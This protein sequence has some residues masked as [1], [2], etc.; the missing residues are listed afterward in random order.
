MSKKLRCLLAFLLFF[1]GISLHAATDTE[2]NRYATAADAA[3]WPS[4]NEGDYIFFK[5]NNDGGDDIYAAAGGRH[6]EIELPVGKKILIYEGDYERILING[7]S[8]LGTPENPTIVTN[9]GGQVRWGYSEESNQYRSLELYNFKHLHLTGKYDAAN[10][11]GD[12]QFLGHDSGAALG[13][14]DYYERYGLWGNPRWSGPTYRGKYG[15][16]VRIFRFKTVKIDYVS[17]WGGYF[18]SFNVKTDNPSK[19]GEV[20]VDIQD[21]FA[22]FGEGEAFYISY[23]TK[24]HNQDITKLTLKNNITA[25]TGA[26]ALQTDNLAEGS[27]IENNV[28]L[29]SATF[30][31]HPFQALY[32]DNLHQFSFVEGG[33]TVQNNILV[34]T[35]GAL[36]NFRY[37]D[38]NSGDV[39][40]RTNP[41]ASKPVTM[42]NNFYGY[43]RTNM[44]YMWQGDGITPYH[45]IDNVYGDI[46]VPCTDDTLSAP[47]KEEAGFFKLGNSNTEITF[48]G[49]IYP[50]ARELYFMSNG[51]GKN[52]TSKGNLQQAAP[53]IQ[54]KNSG[55]SNGI[56]WR[57]ISVWSA[58]YA[59]TPKSSGKNKNGEWIPYVLDDIVIFYDSAGYTKFFKCIQAHA[60]DHNPN[61]ASAYWSQIK[62]NGRNMPP[63]DLRIE[64]GSYYNQ[65][66]M[67]LAYNE[68]N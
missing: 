41:S 68:V 16:G 67:G 47:A 30:Y 19:P 2:T 39:T 64:K 22:G 24:A 28:C 48:E 66:G 32:Q 62:W 5:G 44:G 25:F 51:S 10:Q 11:T 4:V 21:C 61:T 49:N 53:A 8:C 14:G 65:R 9:L 26:E 63:L 57:R 31:R 13:S 18:A 36:H 3:H 37:R 33:I 15:N 43:G 55:F 29:G 20:E 50:A 59:N 60:G 52:V 54:F 7:A 1:I 45:F 58:K 40:D 34:G 17:S 38:A 35:N 46:T 23:S 12:S 6:L 42:R 56:D 27:V